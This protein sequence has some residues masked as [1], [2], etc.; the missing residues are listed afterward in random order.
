MTHLYHLP[1]ASLA[2]AALL[3]AAGPSEA[4]TPTQLT[5]KTNGEILI[6]TDSLPDLQI[7]TEVKEVADRQLKL[8]QIV[9][10]CAPAQGDSVE[11]VQKHLFSDGTELTHTVNAKIADS[12]VDVAASWVA[13]SKAP[14]FSRVDL[15][16]PEQLCDDITV[17]IGG[18]TA[19]PY[20]SESS[21]FVTYQGSEPVVVKRRSTGEFLFRVTGDYSSVVP[22][23]YVQQP[24]AG[25]MLRLLTVPEEIKAGIA[26]KTAVN[27]SLNFGPE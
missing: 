1:A 16:I 5:L 15:W 26:D 21:P 22:A 2:I 11:R 23:F 20:A 3:C 27:W 10:K 17:E 19:F 8:T 9:E 24:S 14:G 13:S 7:R 18:Q 6:A 4:L 12:Q 25:L